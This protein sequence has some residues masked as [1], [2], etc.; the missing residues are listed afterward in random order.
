MKKI[1]VVVL[2][3][4]LSTLSY[5]F[6][7]TKYNTEAEKLK[8]IGVF[9]GTENGFEL[10]R[11]PTRLEGAVMFVRLLG[12]ENIASE[13]KNE[14]PFSDVPMW[15]DA[16][17]GYLY[18]NG[19]TD[20]ISADEFGSNDEL[21][22]KSYLTFMLRSLKY[23][24]S[25]GDFSWSKATEKSQQIGL[26]SDD[27]VTE[28]DGKTFLRDHVASISYSTLKQKLKSGDMS[29]SQKLVSDG[30]FS[31]A[32]AI[33]MGVISMNKENPQKN[34]FAEGTPLVK[35]GVDDI[36][37]LGVDGFTGSDLEVATQIR[38]WQIGNMIYASASE[39]YTDVSYSMRWNYAFPGIYTTRDMI[40]NMKDGNE[41]YGVCFHYAVIFAEIAEYY[42]L[43]VRIMNT[44][45]KHSDVMEN[46][47]YKAT[48]TGLGL[49]EYAEFKKWVVSKG[50]KIEDY[51][52]EAVRL[53]MGETALHYR[54][55][56]KIDDKWIAFDN[57]REENSTADDY[58]F[59]EINWQ[60]GNQEELFNEYISRIKNGEDLRSD[61]DVYQTYNGFLEGM[62]LRIELDEL[63]DYTGIS[64]DLGQE[65]RAAT[66]DDL[67]QGYG[68]IPYYNDKRDVL[69]YMSNLDWLEE[70]IDEYMGVKTAIEKKLGV[71]FYVLVDIILTQEDDSSLPYKVY[72]E[73]Y[74]GYTGDDISNTITEEMY[75][76]YIK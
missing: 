26:I 71:K 30:A 21:D 62:L 73:Q 59:I 52:Y 66:Q 72:A 17:V 27:F 12:A 24:D 56:V 4:V 18:A 32:A 6:A 41:I 47:F 44:T 61:E 75:N 60:E 54:A 50:L 16:Y 74:L 28:L 36:E 33:S 69:K 10:D 19:L 48:A 58:D 2:I 49:D 55:E 46:L 63:K 37:K 65:K 8:E 57:Y 70:E 23:N 38:D 20:G 3:F 9:Q 15:G 7:D 51:P 67:F 5:V 35:F 39:H 11:T 1:I 29:L 31:E 22:A 34:I 64:D 43:D 45:L 40:D 13:E 76:L 68:L 25:E 42:D 14:H 53:V